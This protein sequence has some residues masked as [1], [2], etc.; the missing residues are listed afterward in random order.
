MS[1]GRNGSSAVAVASATNGTTPSRDIDNTPRSKVN[2][3]Q[4]GNPITNTVS[5]FNNTQI[6]EKIVSSQQQSKMK[7][8]MQESGGSNNGGN[9]CQ[10]YGKIM[11]NKEK[12]NMS[13]VMQEQMNMISQI[14]K[15]AV[16]QSMTTD[17]TVKEKDIMRRIHKI[18]NY[19]NKC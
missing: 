4:F 12:M 7:S 2:L 3:R 6:K 15:P 19:L 18:E 11:N 8:P 10:K 1:G 5:N 9:S 14:K 13:A 17:L 16:N